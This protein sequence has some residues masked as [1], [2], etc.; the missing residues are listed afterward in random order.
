M[1]IGFD[2]RPLVGPRTGVGAW[3]E[4][5]L[6][7]LA[8]STDWSFVGFLP[9]RTDLEL[10]AP[11]RQRMQV[12]WPSLPLPGTL[13]LHTLAAGQIG[14]CVEVFL[15]TLAILPRR[16]A[17]PGVAVVHDLTPRTHAGHHTVANRFCF[18]AY[19]EESVLAAD[20]V[21]CVS[22][23]TRARLGE[24]L[25]VQARAAAV[26]SPGVD[27]FFFLPVATP[28]QET[29]EKFA[30]GAPFLVQLGTLEP[31]K[32]VVTLLEAHGRLLQRHPNS[33]ALVLAGGRGWGGKRLEQA[34][35]RHPAP[36]RVHLPGYVT[37]EEARALLAHAEI[38]VVASEE[39]G[40]GL[41]LAEAM[42]CG[43][44]CVASDAPALREV[45]GGA[46]R[47]FP[48]GNSQALAA[49]LEEVLQAPA[50]DQLSARAR[51][52]ARRWRWEVVTPTWHALLT[53]V[54]RSRRHASSSD[55]P[56]P[57]PNGATSAARRV[58]PPPR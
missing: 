11:V 48:R 7:G 50:R 57:C 56:R 51:Q 10:P 32:G 6:G 17:T 26:I 52:Q 25:P 3:L 53:E 21:V 8:N 19:L 36:G 13:W 44:V 28:R 23:A 16:L 45:A 14:S 27:P 46:A 38:V 40:F 1:R 12:S 33:P 47:H 18:N 42:A 5:L 34:L 30:G 43:A 24:L 2:A 9:R 49:A 39:E 20:A 4:G 54:A 15:G 22:H 31:R 55:C 37:R 35:A 29:R 41:P 58:G